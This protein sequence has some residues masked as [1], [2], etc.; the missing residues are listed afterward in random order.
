MKSKQDI[1]ALKTK[2]H[3][4][5]QEPA[6]RK[7]ALRKPTLRKEDEK[8]LHSVLRLDPK[9]AAFDCDGTLWSGD[10]GEG[11]FRWEMEHGLISEE[12]ASWARARHADYKAGLVDEDTMCGEMVTL[13]AGLADADLQTAADRFVDESIAETIFPAMQ[14]LVHQLQARGCEI[15]AVSSSNQWVVRAGV[16]PFG[17][18]PERILSAEVLV[19]NGRITDRLV[20]VPSGP[21]KPQAIRDAV[22]KIPDAAFG[23]SKWDADML[24]MA[25]AGFAVN[26]SP[27]LEEAA[28]ENC[29]PIYFPRARNK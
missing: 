25:K 26:P 14:E 8:F 15:W 22:G 20:R 28:K 27:E 19:E 29:W 10:V 23:D 9:L 4:D 7:L 24:A 6:L 2:T 18:P 5:L 3:P 12:T 16:R 13:H 21:G 11:F 1:S 17:I